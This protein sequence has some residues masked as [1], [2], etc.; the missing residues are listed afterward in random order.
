MLIA[1]QHPSANRVA[2]FRAWLRLGYCVSKGEKGIRIW[3]RVRLRESRS[4]HGSNMAA[5]RRPAPNVFKLSA[6]FAQTRGDRFAALG[7]T[8]GVPTT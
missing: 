2:G 8:S 7:A 4:M 1:M 6:V 5:N 3:R